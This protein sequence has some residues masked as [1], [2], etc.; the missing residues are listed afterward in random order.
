MLREVD[1]PAVTFPRHDDPDV[2][3]HYFTDQATDLHLSTT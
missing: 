3:V 2:A 1:K